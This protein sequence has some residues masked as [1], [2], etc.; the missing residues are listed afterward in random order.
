[1]GAL[2]SALKGVAGQRRESARGAHPA[3]P[4]MKPGPAPSL[5]VLLRPGPRQHA[6]LST[7]WSHLW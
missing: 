2:G 6:P 1:M 5:A 4:Y 3:G 7:R